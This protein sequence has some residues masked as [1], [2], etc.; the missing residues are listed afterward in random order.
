VSA[1]VWIPS[2]FRTYTDGRAELPVHAATV[3][4][5]LAE[6]SA[7]HPQLRRHLFADDGA[8]RGFV[9]VFVKADDV[10]V[11]AAP[12]SAIRDGDALLVLPNVA[13]GR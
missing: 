12:G 4:E 7:L 3:G 5:A 9:N 2:A 13:G 6:V 1:T 10:L 11:L 8:L